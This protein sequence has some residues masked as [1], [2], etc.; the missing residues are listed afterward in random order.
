[1]VIKGQ[2]TD[3]QSYDL[4]SLLEGDVTDIDNDDEED[5]DEDA[6]GSKSF[7]TRP[8]ADHFEAKFYSVRC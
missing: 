7:K 5:D 2:E 8:F 6:E 3:A 1:M 4:D